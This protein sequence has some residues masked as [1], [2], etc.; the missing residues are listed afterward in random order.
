MQYLLSSIHYGICTFL[1]NP[2]S[3]QASHYNYTHTQP[4]TKFSFLG[5]FILKTFKYTV[6]V[7]FTTY[8]YQSL[9]PPLALSIIIV[10]SLTN[11]KEIWRHTRG[12][13]AENYSK[14]EQKIHQMNGKRFGG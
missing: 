14:L 12:G 8:P 6:M 2:P 9:S 5:L 7:I 1:V 10:S 4:L 11:G 13:D 3:K